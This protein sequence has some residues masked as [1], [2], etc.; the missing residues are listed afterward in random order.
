MKKPI[1]P[2]EEDCRI[3]QEDKLNYSSIVKKIETLDK[4][5]SIKEKEIYKE[6]K[7]DI[8]YTRISTIVVYII[9]VCIISFAA[10]YWEFLI[11]LPLSTFWIPVI[12]CGEIENKIFSSKNDLKSYEE[13]INKE[14]EKLKDNDSYRKIERYNKALHIFD[15]EIARYNDFLE[16]QTKT[17]WT[18][19]TGHKFEHEVAKLFEKNGYN[20][21]VTKGSGDGGIDIMLT[22]DGEN[23]AVQ[24][25]HHSKPVGPN[26]F[27]A[28]Q[29]VTI[30]KNFDRGFF[31]SL[32]GFTKSVPE[33]AKKNKEKIIID[34]YSLDDLIKLVKKI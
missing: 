16:K 33:E 6:K 4:N 24:C 29:A 2:K 32:N 14:K 22:K 30:L 34:L 27:R 21:T 18:N 15:M 3:T 17:F 13:Y 26:D 19:L 25:K 1:K 10:G 5:I 23:I 20:A 9:I 8:K 11:G 12:I 7:D 31:V 28:F